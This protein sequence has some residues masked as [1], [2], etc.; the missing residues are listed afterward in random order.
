MTEVCQNN[1][2]KAHSE[3]WPSLRLVRLRCLVRFWRVYDHWA[4]EA[5]AREGRHPHGGA[6]I[7]GARR[8]ARFGTRVRLA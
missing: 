7:V 1:N 4:A 6:S 8:R 2:E 5:P 3:V